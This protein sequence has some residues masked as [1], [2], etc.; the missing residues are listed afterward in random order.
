MKLDPET[1]SIDL[2]DPETR[3]EVTYGLVD[4]VEMGEETYALFLPVAETH[5]GYDDDAPILIL[6]EHY[7]E[8]VFIDDEDEFEAIKQHVTELLA[9]PEDD[10]A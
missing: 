6:R 7:G 5:S 8:L 9:E 10:P 2:Y 4:A 1:E 3:Q